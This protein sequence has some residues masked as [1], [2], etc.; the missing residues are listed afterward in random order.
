M[1]HEAVMQDRVADSPENSQQITEGIRYSVR[2]IGIPPRPSI[3]DEIDREMHKAEPDFKHLADIIGSDVALAAS[4]IKV[5]NSPALGMGRR[6][7]TV[8]DALLVLGLKLTV[9]TIA[10]IVLQRIFPNVPHLERFWDSAARCA[11]VSR[12]LV[13]QLRCVRTISPD[14]AFTF[15]LFRD[16]G[17][18]VLMIPF[19]DYAGTLAEA[20]RN[21]TA[22]FTAVEHAALGI[23]HTELGADLAADW[24]LPEEVILAIRRHHDAD[25]FGLKTDEMTQVRAAMLSAVALVADHLTQ[26]ITGLSLDCEWGKLGE[27]AQVLLGLTPESLAQLQENAAEIVTRDL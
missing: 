1:N 9:H 25:L 19:P 21:D 10:A 18:P 3:L 8:P 12:W 14:D 6:V 15:G 27:R 16:C 24:R 22:P 2:N 26:E 20:N 5:A 17:I 4:I 13:M 11:R 7:R 23:S